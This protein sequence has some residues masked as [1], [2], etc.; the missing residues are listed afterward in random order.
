MTIPSYSS[1]IQLVKTATSDTKFTLATEPMILHDVMVGCFT[2]DCKFGDSLKQEF[3]M[4]VGDVFTFTH[5]VDI[6]DLFFINNTAGSN[7][8]IVIV[9][10]KD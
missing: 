7:T 2:N 8:K 6:E 9:G 5:P 10:V 1:F 4:N 3:E